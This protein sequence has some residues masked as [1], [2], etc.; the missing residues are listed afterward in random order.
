[1]AWREVGKVT[2]YFR[3][4]SVA[5]VRLTDRLRL[6]DHICVLGSTSDFEQDVTSM[7]V[8]HEPIEV[9]EKGQ[10]IGLLVVERARSGDTVYRVEE[11]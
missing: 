6:G 10:E 5:A 8:E 3:R 9:A 11:E 1:M 4:L 2:H 7:E